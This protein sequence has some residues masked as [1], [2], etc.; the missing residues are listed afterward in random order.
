VCQI[1]K[2]N[3]NK[4]RNNPETESVALAD[5]KRVRV[6]SPSML[7]FKRFMRNKL[8]IL[9]LAII[10][11]MFAFSFIGGLIS[12]YSQDDVFKR[13][14]SIPLDYAAAVY[15]SELRY[16]IAEGKDFPAGARSATMLNLSRG[17]LTFKSGD[18]TYEFVNLIDGLYFITA[19]ISV[20]EVATLAGRHTVEGVNGFTADEIFEAAFEKAY[21][22]GENYFVCGDTEYFITRSNPRRSVISISDDIGVA[23]MKIYDLY[24]NEYKS[25]AGDIYFRYESEIAV[26]SGMTSF[27]VNGQ[28]YEAVSYEEGEIIISKNGEHFVSVSDIIVNPVDSELFL[29]IDYKNAVRDAIKE[30]RTAFEFDHPET[31]KTIRYSV[32]AGNA[33]FVVKTETLT[34]IIDIYSSPSM[35]H[36]LGTDG[37]GMDMMTRL[38]YGGRI[39][40]LVGF[41]VV[42]IE[43]IIGVVIGGISGYFGR[44]IDTFLMRF[45]D[46][47]NTIPDIPLLIIFG[48]ILD[49]YRV[50]SYQRIMLLM[51]ILG[52]MGWTGIARVVRGQIL[53]LREQDFMIATEALGLRV[54]RR[55]FRHLVPNVMP[56][57]I[58][59]ATMG[60]GGV[61][62]MEATL[63]FL[64]LGV[65]YPQA[66][67]GSI[68]NAAMTMHIMTEYWFAWIPA[69]ILILLTVLGFNFVGDGLRDAFDPKMKR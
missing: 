10:F 53:S 16:T 15:N 49:A 6:L 27:S 19:N 57:L 43:I 20:A 8:A 51:I 40:L 66:S 25:E 29:E 41:I 33:R 18:V 4:D 28:N 22:D 50:E 44:W 24:K 67:W 42:L 9:G 12:P 58:V 61:I 5:E 60:L 35:E 68:I 46:L 13:L 48:S 65:K 1:N 64:G 31:G 30:D 32:H 62:I 59:Q 34:E 17:E 38:M 11:L 7:V 21:R 26:R 69:G 63:S 52:F 39:S 3:D 2:D 37:N 47:F 23:S 54:S 55:I 36:W 14:E 56:L 45:V